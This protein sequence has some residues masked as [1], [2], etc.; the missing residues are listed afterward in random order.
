[1]CIRDRAY[2]EAQVAGIVRKFIA[3]FLL[4]GAGICL[5]AVREFYHRR[6]L[7]SAEE[8]EAS[9]KK[10]KEQMEKMSAALRASLN[11]LSELMYVADLEN[12]DLLFINEVGLQNFGLDSFEGKKCYEVLQGRDTPCDFCK[13]HI[14]AEGETFTWENTNPVT[15]R[16]YM[17]K[18]R[19]ILWDGRPARMEIAFD[20]TEAEAEKQ[21]LKYTLK[22]EDVIMEC[23]R[24]LYQSK[25]LSESIPAILRY[26]GKFLEAERCYI[27]LVHDDG[28]AYND[29]E[30]CEEG[31]EPVSYTHLDVYKRQA[32]VHGRRYG[33]PVEPYPGDVP[34][35]HHPFPDRV[36]LRPGFLHRRDLGRRRQ[37]LMHSSV[38]S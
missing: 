34:D 19:N 38:I 10:E 20:I 14:S 33:F 17:L 13:G 32:Y 22:T 24:T 8:A 1:M 11:D 5:F 18:D 2:T 15:G 30:W 26:L 3:L 29:F 16:H 27:F 23:V 25:K 28:L 7:K 35:H 31:V 12:Y 4:L 21:E 9:S 6:N 36:L 37:G